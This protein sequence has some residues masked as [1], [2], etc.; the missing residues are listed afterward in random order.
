MGHSRTGR[1]RRTSSQA[2]EISV[3][4]GPEVTTVIVLSVRGIDGR[5]CQCNEAAGQGSGNQH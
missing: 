5:C 2:R 4:H 1:T 3:G